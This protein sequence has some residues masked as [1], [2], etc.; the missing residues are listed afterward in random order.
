MG[1]IHYSEMSVTKYQSLMCNIPGQQQP[2]M[3]CGSLAPTTTLST[4]QELLETIQHYIRIPNI[5]PLTTTYTEKVLRVNIGTMHLQTALSEIHSCNTLH[6]IQYYKFSEYNT[7]ITFPA[8]KSMGLR[9]GSGKQLLSL[10]TK[11]WA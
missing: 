6:F 8:Q 11:V 3:Q 2:Q 7:L 9:H 4:Y 10:T 1:L 5:F